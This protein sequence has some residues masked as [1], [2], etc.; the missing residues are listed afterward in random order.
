[1]VKP[2]QV[3]IAADSPDTVQAGAMIAERGGNVVDIAVATAI[4]AAHTEVLMCSLGGSAFINVMIPGRDAEVVEGADA[5]PLSAAGLRPKE[6][7]WREAHIPYGDGITV[8][9]GHGS[10][11]VPGMLKALETAWQRHGTLSWQEIMAPAIHFARQGATTNQ[12]LAAWLELAG[13]AVFSLQRESRASFF[14]NGRALR[15][16]D[17]FSLPDYQATLELIAAEGARAFYE[18]DI[19][20]LFEKELR[21]NGGHVTRQD[22]AGY[23]AEVR[24]PLLLDSAGYTMALTPPPSIGGA[25]LGS[26]IRLYESEVGNLTTE[27]EKVLLKSRVQRMMFFLRQEQSRAGLSE[28]IAEKVLNLEWLRRYL[29]RV[30]S[31]HTNHLSFAT[32]DGAVVAITMSNGYGSGITVPGTGIPCNNSLGEPELNP[33]GYFR[34]PPAGRF[35]SNM[36]P[37]TAWNKRGTTIAMGTP[38][39]SRI[40][41]T[42]LQGWINY[43]MEGMGAR[44]ATAAPRFHVE[45]ID[46]AFTL[47]VEPGIDTSLAGEMFRLR[48]FAK[49]DMYFGALN[50]AGRDEKGG[51]FV[52]ADRRRHGAELLGQGKVQ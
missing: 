38:G 28:D 46:E 48:A 45:N 19:A 44:A 17:V 4:A 47:Q 36:C 24:K 27:A 9:V 7:S 16:G 8:N 15:A 31:P 50:I 49:P 41:T 37:V 32:A 20:L 25:M 18:G 51:L 14:P 1:M 5:M 2:T 42:L 13:E 22:L 21:D 52:S 11:A 6:A 3:A 33:Q 43:A 23:Q 29:N 39:A 26:M 35:V 10:I 12:T 34:I 30:F 40:T